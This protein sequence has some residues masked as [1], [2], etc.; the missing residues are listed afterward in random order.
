MFHRSFSGAIGASSSV[1]NRYSVF[2]RRVHEFKLFS[3]AITGRARSNQDQGHF[4]GGGRERPVQSNDP[5]VRA[6]V[7][8][9][10]Q[11]SRVLKQASGG[12]AELQFLR[13]EE[14]GARI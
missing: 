9:Y 11:A 12:S 8:C 7:T 5:A 13:E 1:T 6:P 4:S 2:S 10:R 14:Q 3:P